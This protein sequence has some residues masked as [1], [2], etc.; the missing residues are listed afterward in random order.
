[1]KGMNMNRFT[2]KL[3]NGEYK[4][5]QP[6]FSI[7]NQLGEYED[8][9]ES[10]TRK[11]AKQTEQLIE[12]TKDNISQLLLIG[13]CNSDERIKQTYGGER[14]LLQLIK[15]YFCLLEDLQAFKKREEGENGAKK[16]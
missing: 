4:P 2:K 7:I 10:G 16:E 11:K 1:M 6:T 13:M 12:L 14:E 15:G 9:V 3:S 5:T 8:L